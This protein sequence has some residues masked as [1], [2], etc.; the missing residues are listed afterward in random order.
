MTGAL[1]GALAGATVGYL[2]Y[3]EGGREVRDRFDPAVD[4]LR[5][6]FARFQ[7]TIEKLGDMANEGVRMVTEFQAA[8]GHEAAFAPGFA[9]SRSSH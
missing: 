3:T 6:E 5:Q 8:R 4:D 1:L 2:F 7:R 9:G